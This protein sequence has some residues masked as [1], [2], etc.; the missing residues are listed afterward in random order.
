MQKSV[1]IISGCLI[2]I[3]F[4]IV[5]L[6]AAQPK[7]PRL[8]KPNFNKLNIGDIL[9]EFKEDPQ[10][11]R[12]LIKKYQSSLKLNI[13]KSN[14]NEIIFKLF[15][16]SH[17][18]NVITKLVNII[19]KA[20]IADLPIDPLINKIREGLAKNANSSLILGTLSWKAKTLKEAKDILNQA[21][22]KGYPPVQQEQTITMISDFLAMGISKK[23]ILKLMIKYKTQRDLYELKNLLLIEVE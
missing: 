9:K 7:S 2:I 15:Q 3:L 1:R 13:D 20:K 4:I 5:S 11:A 14:L 19:I 16:K 17:S 23:G 8:E 6:A 12:S 21:I 18:Q 10:K 22:F